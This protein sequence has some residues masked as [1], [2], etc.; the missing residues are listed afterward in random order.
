MRILD[1]EVKITNWDK[2]TGTNWH[3]GRLILE[4]NEEMEL[5]NIREV[6]NKIIH[7]ETFEWDFSANNPILI[8]YARDGDPRKWVRAEVD[9]VAIAA[10]CGRFIS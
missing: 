8:C 10:F 9:L 4:N 1:D 7:A 5:P 2:Q 6:S 3:C